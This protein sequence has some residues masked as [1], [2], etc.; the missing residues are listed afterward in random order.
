MS[1]HAYFNKLD[2][3]LDGHKLYHFHLLHN[4]QHLKISH[5]ILV[6]HYCIIFQFIF[7]LQSVEFQRT[8]SFQYHFLFNFTFIFIFSGLSISNFS[9]P[10]CYLRHLSPRDVKILILILL[11]L[12]LRPL[13]TYFLAS[14]LFSLYYIYSTQVWRISFSSHTFLK[15]FQCMSLS[16]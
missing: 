16:R 14:F 2:V 6:L 10:L 15:P 9:L 11:Q 13:V 3:I 7:T 8:L 4:S 1:S 5:S 12:P